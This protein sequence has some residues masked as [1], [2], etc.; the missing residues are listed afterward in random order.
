MAAAVVYDDTTADVPAVSSLE[1]VDVTAKWLPPDPDNL[2][3]RYLSGEGVKPLAAEQGVSRTTLTKFLVSQGIAIRSISEQQRIN[4]T[5]STPSQRRIRA[6]A[7]HAAR[8]RQRDTPETLLL[9]AQR[10]EQRQQGISPWETV[11]AEMFR[12]RG[13]EFRQQTAVGPYNADFTSGSVAVE[14]FG[15]RWHFSGRHRARAQE[16]FRYFLDRGWHVVILLITSELP[17]RTSSADYIITFCDTAS[18]FPS[19]VRQYRMVGGDAEVL[20]R[21][22]A[23]D[24]QLTTEYPR[25]RAR[26]SLG[27]YT[28]IPR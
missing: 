1:V 26:N 28:G 16:R 9:R 24:D 27:Q 10:N 23:D 20:I 21:Q 12:E 3:Q 7:A 15:G 13:L 18:S 19:S 17:L 6:A 14:V 2:V 22:S 25:R 8:R 5:R 11:V 4:A